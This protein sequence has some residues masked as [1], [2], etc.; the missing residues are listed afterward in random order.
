[1]NDAPFR[2]Q[3][4]WAGAELVGVF[5]TVGQTLED[6]QGSPITVNT[7][8]LGRRFDRRLPGPLATLQPGENRVSW[9]K[10]S[11]PPFGSRE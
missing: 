2:I 8:L 3:V 4:P 1:M 10:T 5:P 11:A 6:R 9:R 7:D